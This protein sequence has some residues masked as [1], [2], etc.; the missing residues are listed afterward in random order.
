MGAEVTSSVSV[1]IPTYNG[2]AW[3]AEALESVI[4]QTHPPREIVVVDDAS[5]DG[6]ARR[7]Q[8]VASNAPVPVDLIELDANRGSPA[9]ALNIGIDRAR[10]DLIAIIDQ[11][12]LFLPS[13]LESQAGALLANPHMS[14]VFSLFCRHGNGGSV[15][16]AIAARF[17][18]RRIRRRMHLADGVYRC[19][20]P[21]A[22]EELARADNNFFGGFPG[23]LFR[24]SAW[25]QKGGLDE[26]L[27]I[28]S[29]LEFLCWLCTR[30]PV[31]FIPEVHYRRREHGSNL[32]QRSGVRWRLDAISVLLRY[33]DVPGTPDTPHILR[34]AIRRH[35]W[36]IARRLASGGHRRA[37]REVGDSVRSTMRSSWRRGVQR[38]AIP[39]YVGY[40]RLIG[41]PWDIPRRQADEAI[42]LAEAAH[43]K[44]A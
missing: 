40:Y 7:V 32:T 18:T 5:S 9:P 17:R 41:R 38:L 1:V 36:A 23:F 44:L 6:T 20:G 27:V 30:G 4:S 12:D 14:F 10:G 28:G 11:D 3:I 34:D 31:G 8:S 43:S 2:E 13:K 21:V 19:D 35:L 33:A 25:Q 42:Q 29:D 16:D 39:A 15:R 37:A 22:L 26:G 24:R